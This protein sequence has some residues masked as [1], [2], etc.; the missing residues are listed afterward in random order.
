MEKIIDEMQPAEPL[1]VVAAEPPNVIAA[2]P[3]SKPAKKPKRIAAGKKL[4]EHNKRAKEKMLEDIAEANA[5]AN[6]AMSTLKNY[7][8][9]IK[10]DHGLPVGVRGETP[11]QSHLQEYQTPIVISGVLL[12][13]GLYIWSSRPQKTQEHPPPQQPA[14]NPPPAKPV[15]DIY[16]I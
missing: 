12:L 13:A 16:A 7:L 1:N 15:D 10:P 9:H 5:N 4:Q 8:E 2:E 3:S 6:D 11:R 14:A